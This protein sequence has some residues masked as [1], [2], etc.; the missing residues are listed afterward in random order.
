MTKAIIIGAGKIGTE[1][2]SQLKLGGHIVLAQASRTTV[3]LHERPTIKIPKYGDFSDVT[4]LLKSDVSNADV[5]MLAIPTGSDNGKTELN[6]IKFFLECGLPVVTSAKGAH[7]YHFSDLALDLSRIGNAATFGGGTDML[8]MLRRRDLHDKD[9]TIYAVINGTLNYVW[10]TVQAGG[11]FSAAISDAKDLGYAEPNNDDPID[12]VNGELRDACLKATICHN[13][14]LTRGFSFLSPSRFN[15]TPL[16]KGDIGR[17]TSRNARYRFLVTFT[18]VDDPDEI[19]EGAPGSMRAEC[20][21]WRIVGGFH[22]VKAESPWYDWLR[23]V[24][25]VNNGFTV[26]SAFGKDTGHS[27]TGPGAGPETTA[28]AMVRDMNRLRKL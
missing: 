15:I 11:S 20:G 6:Y 26:H 18:T 25:G 8:H 12:I 16:I 24:D 19:P 10:S 13:V 27:M 7:A 1:L 23:Q 5:A 28:A 17:L 3:H 21:R 14:A 9:V 2:A 22:D 4:R